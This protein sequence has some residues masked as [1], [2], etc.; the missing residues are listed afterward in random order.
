MTRT[1]EDDLGRVL[2][3]K[4]K[5]AELEAEIRS[6]VHDRDF[7]D[8]LMARFPGAVSINWIAIRRFAR[9]MGG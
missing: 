8:E 3:A 9:R 7:I 4:E 6:I 2:A 1:F 5:I